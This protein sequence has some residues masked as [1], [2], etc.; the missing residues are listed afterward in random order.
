MMILLLLLLQ[1]WPVNF[2]ILHL[3]LLTAH[4]LYLLL[5]L[6]VF[7]LALWRHI[8]HCIFWFHNATFE[9][10]SLLN[11]NM[12]SYWTKCFTYFH[13]IIII[14]FYS[15]IVII[16]TIILIWTLL[17]CNRLLCS[18]TIYLF[19]SLLIWTVNFIGLSWSRRLRIYY[20][21]DFYLLLLQL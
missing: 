5:L 9:S 19:F 1:R 4:L 21:T 3:L 14:S 17:V 7:N 6:S 11:W 2:Q 10:L 16:S 12:I 8:V 15:E 13:F 20:L 18:M